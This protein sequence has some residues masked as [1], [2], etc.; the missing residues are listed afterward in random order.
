MAP[1][2]YGPIHQHFF[3][4][5]MDMMVDGPDNSVYEVN[6]VADP[7]GPANPHHNAFHTEATLLRSEGQDDLERLLM[8]HSPK[9]Q[10]ILEAARKRFREGGGIPHEAFWNEVEAALTERGVKL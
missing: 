4:V 8:G 6:T 10:A 9:L 7:P 2:V 5:R 1:Q 3:N